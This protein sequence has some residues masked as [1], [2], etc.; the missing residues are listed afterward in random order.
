MA[1]EK[2]TV[3]IVDDDPDFL[4]QQR[5]QLE[6]AGYEVIEAANTQE[7]RGKI[8]QGGFDLAVLDLMMDETDAGFTLSREIKN[9]DESIPVILVTAVASETGMEFGA[10]T[11]EERSWIRAD[12]LLD[13][14]VRFEQ[15][16][17][18]IE[19]LTKA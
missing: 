1:D 19:R 2:M 9:K 16:T 10:Q 6:N 12:A 4:F 17:R 15:L 5:L 8:A 18:E 14:P 3:L 13:K 11:R 7:A